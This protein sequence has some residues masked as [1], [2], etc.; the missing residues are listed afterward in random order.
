MLELKAIFI[1]GQT[2]CKEKSYKHIR[3]MSDNITSV[4]YVNNKGGIKSELCNKT[5]KELWV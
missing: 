4:S 2:Y 3:V 5:A 1:G